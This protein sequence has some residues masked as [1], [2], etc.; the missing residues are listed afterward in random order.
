MEQNYTNA[1]STP[2]VNF[3][4]PSSP[5]YGPQKPK[6]SSYVVPLAIVVAGLLIAGAIL[7]KGSFGGKQQVISQNPN[8]N[9][10]NVTIAPITDKDHILGSPSAKIF[11]VEYSDTECPFCKQFHA[12]LQQ[13][14]DEYGSDGRVAWVYRHFPLYKG[15]E[16]QPA[17]H[18]RS[19]KEAE[20]TECAA[21]L[22]G[23][24]KFWAYIDELYRL[25]P[26]NNGF[27]PAKL[28]DIATSV[29]LDRT[30]FSACLESGKYAAKIENDYN[31][32][33]LAG[34]QATPYSLV[35]NPATGEKVVIDQG[36]IPFVSLRVII[37]A[38]LS[39]AN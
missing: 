28:P 38:M 4:G 29:G 37:D 18:S 13:V 16:T 24:T 14:V 23:N 33:L 7:V 39:K 12:T 10:A 30:A 5:Q 2:P 32:A 6:G 36:A 22:G 1:N 8:D 27:D 21:E 26:S 3:N 20:A 11:I 25:T 34:A 15:S 17:L 19:G 35:I 31:N 9:N